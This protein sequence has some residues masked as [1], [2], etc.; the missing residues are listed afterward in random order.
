MKPTPHYAFQIAVAGALFALLLTPPVLAQQGSEEE[1]KRLEITSDKMRTEDNGRK[2]VFTGNVRGEWE[3]VVL[4]SEILE[5]YTQPKDNTAPQTSAS[6]EDPK[7]GQEL[8]KIIAIK[9]VDVIK[10][11]KKARGDKAI[12]YDKTQKM[13]LTGTPHATAWENENILEGPEMIFYMNEDRF[14]VTNGV[15]LILFP[16]NSELKQV[17]KKK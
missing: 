5:V 1:P 7:S 17:D 9:N 12:Y 8:E 16:K 15:K 10:G 11:T 3:D 13:V 6:G 14:E 4:T 2:I